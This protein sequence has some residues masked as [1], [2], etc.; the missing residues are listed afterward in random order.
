MNM[1]FTLE[2]AEKLELGDALP[3]PARTSTG[4]CLE[5]EDL[6]YLIYQPSGIEPVI[7]Y[8][9]ISGVYELET[10]DIKD[11]SRRRHPDI[12]WKGGDLRLTNPEHVVQDWVVYLTL[13]N[14]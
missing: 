10:L 1:G 5:N 11:G 7:I 13:K 14:R 9:L 6:K 8:D 2:Y 12:L 3:Q 4:Y